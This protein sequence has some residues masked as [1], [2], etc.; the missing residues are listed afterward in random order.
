LPGPSRD[1]AAV[2][3]EETNA[4]VRAISSLEGDHHR[5]R[6]GPMEVRK[7]AKFLTPTERED[8]VRACVLMKADIDGTMWNVSVSSG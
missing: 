3:L 2:Q 4:G 7:N 5:P 8:F 6:G 1:Q